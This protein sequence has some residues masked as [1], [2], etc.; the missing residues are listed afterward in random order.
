MMN[1]YKINTFK[2]IF[3]PNMKCAKCENR[4]GLKRRRQCLVCSRWYVE[5]IYCKTCSIKVKKEGARFSKA[6]YCSDCFS[7][8]TSE[9]SVKVDDLP[10]P[11]IS[12]SSF[13][14]SDDVGDS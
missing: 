9:T 4:L 12:G 5:K 14:S 2:S 8:R 1:S 13:V 3:K 7:S 6:R 11:V 10:S